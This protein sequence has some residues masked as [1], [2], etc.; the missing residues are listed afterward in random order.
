MRAL[1]TGASGF[2][3]GHLTVELARRGHEVRALVRPTSSLRWLERTGLT[4]V[5][6]DLGDELSLKKAAA[7]ADLVFHLAAVIHASS[8]EKH[9]AVNIEGTE[10]LLAACREAAPRLQ[11][12]VFVSSIAASGPSIKGHFKKE[13][14]PCQP[15][16][17]YGQSKLEAEAIVRRYGAAFPVVILRPPNVLGAREREVQAALRA[18]RCRLKPLLG[19]K[20]KQTSFIMVEDLVEAVLLCAEKKEA[21]GQTYNVTDGRAYSWREPLD[22]LGRLLGRHCLPL[23]YGLLIVLAGS[24]EIAFKLAGHRPP[25]RCSALRSIRENYWIF[26]GSK[27][28]LELGFQ[29][30]LTLEEGLR[31]IVA[32]GL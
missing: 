9:R 14:D 28:E 24:A 19:T 26:D 25:V 31:K 6:G 20:D 30:R 32:S 3:G 21:V 13:E 2:I 7:G 10:N 27:I 11:R 17:A 18:L 8:W 23:P 29:A 16:S 5:Q 22:I 15:I 4:L 12:F 1:V